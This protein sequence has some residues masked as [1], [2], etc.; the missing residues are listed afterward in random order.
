[1]LSVAVACA[2]CVSSPFA[3]VRLPTSDDGFAAEETTE[4]RV[5]HRVATKSPVELPNRDVVEPPVND[6]RLPVVTLRA[7]RDKAELVEAPAERAP[8]PVPDD[9]EAGRAYRNALQ[10][11]NA[12]ENAKAIAAL[13]EFVRAHP[14]DM[15]VASALYWRAE[16]YAA[17]DDCARAS[18]DLEAL[19][20][21]G[22]GDKEPDALF[23][24][25]TCQ[26]KVGK[27][28]ASRATLRKL[29]AKFPRSD[30]AR[31]SRERL[32]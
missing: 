32:E 2:A 26:A 17:S 11:F 13:T 30:A 28:D 22:A 31:R 18:A 3:D 14:D 24:L 20:A 29:G 9:S 16:A 27:A 15:R 4:T 10:L 19:L 12:G 6:T 8:T 1:M 21:R 5:V 25:G 23:A 7:N